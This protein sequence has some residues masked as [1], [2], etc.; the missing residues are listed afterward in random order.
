MP[1]DYDYEMEV[2]LD[3]SSRKI[4]IFCISLA[5]RSRSSKIPS[6]VLTTGCSSGSNPTTSLSTFGN[7]ED[8]DNPNG[9]CSMYFH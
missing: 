4:P 3:P 5:D 7:A 2:A 1:I 6:K 9:L 8:L